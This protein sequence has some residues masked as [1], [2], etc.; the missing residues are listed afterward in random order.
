MKEDWEAIFLSLALRARYECSHLVRG[1]SF[2][3][4]VFS[5][6]NLS[7]QVTRE[8]VIETYRCHGEEHKA[9]ANQNMDAEKV[10]QSHSESS[11]R[12]M[13]G[14]DIEQSK[15]LEKYKHDREVITTNEVLSN[16]NARPNIWKDG[17]DAGD[18]GLRPGGWCHVVR[19]H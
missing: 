9:R 18:E 12:K 5:I 13:T 11:I 15:F 16:Q 3:L 19:G 4:N 7:C 17:W 14:M 8:A 10:I 2:G 1:M 6:Y